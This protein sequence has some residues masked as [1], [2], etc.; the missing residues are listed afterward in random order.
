MATVE[1]RKVRDD[2]FDAWCDAIDVGFH[3]PRQRGDGALRRQWFEIDRCRGA[4]ADGRPVGTCRGLRMNLA[5]PGGG[6]VPVDGIS[7]VTVSASHRRQGL[8]SRMMAAELTEAAARGESM[9]VLIAAEWPIYGRFGFGAAAD[10]AD[11]HLDAR[12]A[13]FAVPLPGTVE[14]VDQDTARAEAPALYDRFRRRH[15]GSVDRAGYRWDMSLNILR[16]AGKDDPKDQL[17][18]LCRDETGT[19]VGFAVYRIGPE[20]FTRQRPSGTIKI[21]VLFAVD[22]YYEARLWK[23]L[24]DHDWVTQ[25]STDDIVGSSDPLW[26]ELLVDRRAAWSSDAWEGLWL[27]IL[28]PI[29]ALTARTYETAGRIV[30]RIADKDGYADGTFALE[31]GADGRAVCTLTSEV[32]EVTLPV[33]VLGSIYLGGFTADRYHRLGRIEENADGAV[34]RLTALFRTVAAPFNV[35]IF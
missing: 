1:V 34:S 17:Y 6:F 20:V 32:P 26:R 5:V 10:S 25:V 15:P 24:A 9:A 30:L 12:S 27:R 33:E 13:Q 21:E 4:F 2:E 19:A 18:A 29:T 14:L 28:D 3:S 22:P 7:A 23:F 16:A 35:T 8:L 31:A 11:W